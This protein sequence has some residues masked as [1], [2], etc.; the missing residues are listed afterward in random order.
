MANIPNRPK[1][2]HITHV[3]NLS[4]I[5]DEGVI[6]SDA[7][8]LELNLDCEVVGMSSI[9]ARRLYELPVKC[10]PGTRVGQ[11]VPFYF[12]PRSIM[13]YI[14]HMGN[15]PELSYHGGQAPMVHLVAD[16]SKAVAWADAQSRRWA[17]TNRNAGTYYAEF[18][19]NLADLSKVN[20]T[21]VES[22]DFRSADIKDGKQAEFLIEE[23]LPW[24]L[25]DEVGAVDQET[26]ARVRSALRS[27]RHQPAVRIRRSWYF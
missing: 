21:A 17:F 19:S 9:K 13:L 24:D 27:A 10:H 14:L 2:F 5:I 12:C 26:A 25:V 4:R 22:L 6:W 15:S 18:F 16:L 1:I 8:R 23:L 3:E 20:W 11:Y 7:K